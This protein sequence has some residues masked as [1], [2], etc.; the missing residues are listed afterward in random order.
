MADLDDD[1]GDL[2][3]EVPKKVGFEI[4]FN[5]K[6]RR[7][8]LDGLGD[9]TWDLW[10]CREYVLA[11]A[12]YA[13]HV[14][15]PDGAGGDPGPAMAD[16]DAAVAKGDPDMI[17]EALR[18]LVDART[19]AA[20][21]PRDG[22]PFPY[23]VTSDPEDLRFEFVAGVHE[24]PTRLAFLVVG[25]MIPVTM[26]VIIVGMSGLIRQYGETACIQRAKETTDRRIE[27]LTRMHR[28][29]GHM[30]PPLGGNLDAIIKAGDAA[31]RRCRSLLDRFH[32]KV[33]VPPGFTFEIALGDAPP[34]P[35]GP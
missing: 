16:L 30:S 8:D 26:T 6:G 11:V 17:D 27:M 4:S 28:L 19:D 32:Y 18:A 24:N 14:L 35:S 13:R 1:I 25:A 22:I 33:T 2:F 3:R 21:F 12:A 29:E 15:D 34:D 5:D 20:G 10:W 31:E 23:F 7:L 9:I